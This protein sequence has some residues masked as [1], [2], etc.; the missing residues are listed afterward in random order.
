MMAR[1]K[2][3]VLL[4]GDVITIVFSQM[5]TLL[6]LSQSLQ[7]IFTPAVCVALF[8]LVSLLSGFYKTSISHLGVGAVKL[9]L[10]PTIQADR[11]I[12]T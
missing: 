3:A 6:L 12:F 8:C 7:N 11:F 2:L 9:A 10:G 1:V 5:A 4:F